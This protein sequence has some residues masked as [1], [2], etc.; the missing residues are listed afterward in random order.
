MRLCSLWVAAEGNEI[1]AESRGVAFGSGRR[2]N[3]TGTNTAADEQAGR[4]E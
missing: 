4:G 1:L 3:V 2:W